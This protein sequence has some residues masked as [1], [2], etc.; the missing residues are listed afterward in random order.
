MYKERIMKFTKFLFSVAMI[1]G[2]NDVFSEQE[3][4]ERQL[5]KVIVKDSI[6]LLTSDTTSLENVVTMIVVINAYRDFDQIMDE[7][8]Q[9]LLRVNELKLPDNK[10]VLDCHILVQKFI[11]D[12]I[13]QYGSNKSMDDLDAE[14]LS[15]NTECNK[16]IAEF[17][18]VR[19][20]KGSN[21]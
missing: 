11:L 13:E 20:N 8:K 17:Y 12:Q 2:C 1:M 18:T 16:I 9:A 15:K 19:A 21:K 3:N 4:V 10:K 7:A 5:A 14:I 6:A